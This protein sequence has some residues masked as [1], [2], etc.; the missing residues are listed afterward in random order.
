MLSISNRVNMK[1]NETARRPLNLN[2]E[3]KLG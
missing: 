3:D 1:D 2:C